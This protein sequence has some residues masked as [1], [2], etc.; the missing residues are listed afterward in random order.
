MIAVVIMENSLTKILMPIFRAIAAPGLGNPHTPF[1]NE[2]LIS[3]AKPTAIMGTKDIT[4]E[5]QSHIDNG[6]I[7]EIGDVEFEQTYSICC[8]KEDAERTELAANILEGAWFEGKAVTQQEIDLINE[9]FCVADTNSLSSEFNKSAMNAQIM[10][11]VNLNDVNFARALAGNHYTEEIQG[12]L[13]GE[14]PAL[15]PFLSAS[16]QEGQEE[17]SMIHPEMKHALNDEAFTTVNIK[18]TNSIKVLAQNDKQDDGKELLS[19]Y[20]NDE[21]DYEPLEEKEWNTRIGQLLG[22]TENDIAWSNGDKYQH[23]FIHT[24]M[25]KTSE[26]RHQARKIVMLH[27]AKVKGQKPS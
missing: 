26:L 25:Q 23:P 6:Q 11:A 14:S 5:L 13:D 22:Y 18:R 15:K 17:R 21:K 24:L 1:E 9:V 10:N 3:G 19:R 2:L 4:E 8:R 16:K 7:V 27:D 20:F 12:F